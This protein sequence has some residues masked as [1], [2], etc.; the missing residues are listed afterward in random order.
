MA[1]GSNTREAGAETWEVAAQSSMRRAIGRAFY[2]DAFVEAN[3]VPDWVSREMNRH[4]DDVMAAVAVTIE[5]MPEP[6]HP[7]EQLTGSYFRAGAHAMRNDILAALGERKEAPNA[8]RGD[9]GA[10]HIGASAEG[11]PTAAEGGE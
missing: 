7:G 1:E 6:V 9:K 4:V 3:M 11:D 2:G 5:W 10:V 8:E